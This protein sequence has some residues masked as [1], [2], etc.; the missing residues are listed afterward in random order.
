MTDQEKIKRLR[1]A[2]VLAMSHIGWCWDVIEAN[3]RLE[4]AGSKEVHNLLADA[5]IVT[6]S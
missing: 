4:R 3:T 6:S 5:F 2:L 1:E